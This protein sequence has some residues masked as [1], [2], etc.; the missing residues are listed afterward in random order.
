VLQLLSDGA[1]NRH[2]AATKANADSSRSH[3]VFTCVLESKCTEDGV[4][5]IK[6]SCLNLVDLAG[7]ST[8]G[9]SN[10]LPITLVSKTCCPNTLLARRPA[11]VH[12]PINY[13]QQHSSMCSSSESR[14][15]CCL[16]QG[17]DVFVAGSERQKVAEGEGERVKEAG[18]IN[19][20]LAS[21]G[22]VIKK[23][24][25]GNGPGAPATQQTH[26]PYRDSRLTFLL[27]V[28]LLLSSMHA[29]CSK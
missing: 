26:I 12:L 14:E 9:S 7:W 25:E 1:Q 8:A 22:L 19:R 16:L 2:V 18:S 20:S 6:T 21:L 24:V 15:S 4:T 10:I 29:W 23:L 11:C 5:S 27:Q 3:C 13:L 17:S 28:V